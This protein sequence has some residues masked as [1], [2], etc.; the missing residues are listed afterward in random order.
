MS[1]RKI[2]PGQNYTGESAGSA[3]AADANLLCGTC[4][5]VSVADALLWHMATALAAWHDVQD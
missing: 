3:D 5:I 2:S 4:K 1:T